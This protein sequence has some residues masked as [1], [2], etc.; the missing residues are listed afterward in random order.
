LVLSADR[1]K[2]RADGSDLSFITATVT[3]RRGRLVPRAAQRIQFTISGPGEI[4]ATDNGDPTS[5]VVFSSPTRPAFNGKC[6]VIVRG[7]KGAA[8]RLQLTAT[9]EGLRSAKLSLTAAAN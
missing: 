7:T 2:I 5:M 1:Q 4:V 3:D 8:G 6:L 9:A